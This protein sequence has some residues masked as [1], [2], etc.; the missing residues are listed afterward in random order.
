M[1]A[2]VTVMVAVVLRAFVIQTFRIPSASMYPTLWVGDLI[3]VNKL[4]YGLRLPGVDEPIYAGESPKRGEIVVFSRFSDFEDFEE[5][6][7]YVKRV[8]GVPG[9]TVEVRDFKAFVNGEETDRGFD[10][11]LNEDPKSLEIGGRKW[12]PLKLRKGEYFVLGD[13]RV[14]SQDSR[15][16]GPVPGSAIE[17]RAEFIYWSWSIADAEF[18]IRWERIGLDID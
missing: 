11:E 10:V 1:I 18:D 6:K 15:F 17:G 2:C 14:N 13:N 5:T 7:H 9:D 16:F 3:I 12:G 4:V 8:V